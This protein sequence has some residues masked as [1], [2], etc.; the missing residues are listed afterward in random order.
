MTVV[1]SIIGSLQLFNEPII[2]STM[3]SLP[4]SYTPNMD[5]YNMAFSYGNANYSATLS[6]ILAVITIATS[7]VFISLA[8]RRRARPAR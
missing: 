2:M 3:T 5:I 1:L 8:S 6:I 4:P 7:M